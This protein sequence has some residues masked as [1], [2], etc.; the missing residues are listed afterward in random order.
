MAESTQDAP[1]PPGSSLPGMP[2]GGCQSPGDAELGAYPSDLPA[3]E[4]SMVARAQDI[5][6]VLGG[7]HMQLDQTRVGVGSVFAVPAQCWEGG[8]CL[9]SD[10]DSLHS[11]EL[12]AWAGA[13]LPR[14]L[15]KFLPKFLPNFLSEIPSEILSER[16][17]TGNIIL[18][19]MHLCTGCAQ[20]PACCTQR[21]STPCAA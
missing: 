5:L 14:S 9:L 10:S 15:P 18:P 6:I 13:R 16:P 19:F 8:F 17:L 4:P 3:D 2:D 12:A 1:T 7:P 20:H 21:Q 11:S